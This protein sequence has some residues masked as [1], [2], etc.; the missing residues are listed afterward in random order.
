[1]DGARLSI[2]SRPRMPLT[3]LTPQAP[4]H[5]GLRG[6][7]D[8]TCSCDAA[9]RSYLAR[10]SFNAPFS[11]SKPHWDGHALKVQ[12]VN[13]TAGL[14]SGDRLCSEVNIETGARLTLTSPSATRLHTM[15]EGCAEATQHFSIA[16]GARLCFLPSIL[17][18]HRKT[19]YHQTTR[20]DVEAGG[21]LLY[22]EMVAPGRVAHG[23]CFEY[24]ELR[25]D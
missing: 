22:L 4:S 25:F 17:M 16:P 12:M 10:Q 9:G 13:P 7:L 21:E 23:E 1:M 5:R 14:L 8:L 15:A 3:L 24:G 19:R 6:H 18:P 2:S 20:I 11:I